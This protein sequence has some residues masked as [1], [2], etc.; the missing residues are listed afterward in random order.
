MLVYSKN[1]TGWRDVIENLPASLRLPHGV[2]QLAVNDTV[3]IISYM[4]SNN[5]VGHLGIS[6]DVHD[7]VKRALLSP[8]TETLN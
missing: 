8:Q 5:Q 4:D 3:S 2:W 1:Q 7:E 6:G